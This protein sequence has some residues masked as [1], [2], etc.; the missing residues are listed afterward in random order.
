MQALQPHLVLVLERL[1][2]L[3]I[4]VD[5]PALH[6]RVVRLQGVDRRPQRL[7]ALLPLDLLPEQADVHE[8]CHLLAEAGVVLPQP[9]V[10]LR[11]PLGRLVQLL[12]VRLQLAGVGP[13]DLSRAIGAADLV[14]LWVGGQLFKA[15]GVVE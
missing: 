11:Q 15:H 6:A 8:H 14:G 1:E 13:G 3:H 9:P 2:E 4:P 12:D 10:L 7:D 5:P